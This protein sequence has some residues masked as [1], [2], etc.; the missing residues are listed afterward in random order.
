MR[1]AIRTLFVCAA[2]TLFVTG[3]ATAQT[4]K[5][6]PPTAK[7]PINLNTASVDQLDE[8]PGIGRAVAQRIIEYRQKNGG[9]KKVEDLLEGLLT[10][11]SSPWV[12]GRI[13]SSMEGVVSAR[14][15]LEVED[16]S[17]DP[18]RLFAILER[19]RARSLVDLLH[20]RPL[21]DLRKPEDLRRGERRIST[22]L[23]TSIATTAR[24]RAA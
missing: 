23:S 4:D 18:S 5:T 8:L 17:G 14:I 19:A 20:A 2:V 12:R 9:F 7:L 6:V 22:M 15:R 24:S 1:H 11:A 13:L 21:S 3:M 10:N 16:R